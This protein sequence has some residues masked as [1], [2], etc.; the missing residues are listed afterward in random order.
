MDSTNRAPFSYQD[1]L[2]PSARWYGLALLALLGGLGF[3]YQFV[4]T[5]FD[6]IDDAL[7]QIKTPGQVELLLG[8]KGEHGVFLETSTL[9][10]G[11]PYVAAIDDADGLSVSIVRKED[12]FVVPLVD[13]KGNAAY[14]LFGREGAA[15]YSFQVE[16]TGSYLVTVG[17]PPAG[18]EKPLVVAV[19]GLNPNYEMTNI[20]LDASLIFLMIWAIT[21]ASWGTV[22]LLRKK[23][24]QQNHWSERGRSKKESSPK[25]P[26]TVSADPDAILDVRPNGKRKKRKK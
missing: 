24:K 4:M 23:Y 1:D 26:T 7:I 25:E 8:H 9:Y 16:R 11:K 12:D 5:G 14:S 17:E 18:G 13:V 21:I 2:K 15:L 19:S 22:F 10:G 20:L 6:R 3:L